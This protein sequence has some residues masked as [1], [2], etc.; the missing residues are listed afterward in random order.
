MLPSELDLLPRPDLQ[1]ADISPLLL[2]CILLQKDG[3]A[4]VLLE[5]DHQKGEACVVLPGLGVAQQTMSQE[6][7][8]ALTTGKTILLKKQFRYDARSPKVLET[9]EGHTGF[10]VPCWNRVPSIGMC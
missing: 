6:Q 10:G 5:L 1:L 3:G 4:C 8:A 2:P 9:R 7:L